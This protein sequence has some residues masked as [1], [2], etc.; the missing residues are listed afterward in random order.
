[1]D[2]YVAWE[3]LSRLHHPDKKATLNSKKKEFIWAL[4]VI[5]LFEMRGC[6]AVG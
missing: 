3:M 6:N 5:L 1:M 2:N 4:Q